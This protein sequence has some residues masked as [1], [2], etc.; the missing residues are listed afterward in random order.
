MAIATATISWPWLPTPR[1][2]SPSR[3]GMAQRRRSQPIRASSSSITASNAHRPLQ[4]SLKASD[5]RVRR[6]SVPSPP[7]P[8]TP[9]R[10]ALRKAHSSR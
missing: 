3:A 4:S 5:C 7:R 2:L 1:W 6:S 9:S 10:V 8:K